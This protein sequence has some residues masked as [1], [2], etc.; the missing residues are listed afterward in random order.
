MALEAVVEHLAF[1]L[2]D[3]PINDQTHN[4]Y[5]R[6]PSGQI[7]GLLRVHYSDPVWTL[8]FI[9]TDPDH[10]RKGIA[11]KLMRQFLADSDAAGKDVIL[12][13]MCT[14]IV[15]GMRTK[16]LVRW[17]RTFGFEFDEGFET[18]MHRSFIRKDDPHANFCGEAQAAN[19]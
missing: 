11:T 13:P 2:M 5:E 9:W 12:I 1:K 19:A 14:R 16:A 4:Y 8:T 3:A 18:F 17:Y 10:C 15:N 7:I 6:L